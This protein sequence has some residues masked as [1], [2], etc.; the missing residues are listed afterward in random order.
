[1]ILN[2]HD[3]HCR[4]GLLE[5]M[6]LAQSVQQQSINPPADDSA[7]K[8]N[9]HKSSPCVVVVVAIV[10]VTV[11]ALC[12]GH[13][14]RFQQYNHVPSFPIAYIRGKTAPMASTK[15][16]SGLTLVMSRKARKT[17]KALTICSDSK[18]RDRITIKKSKVNHPS[19]KRVKPR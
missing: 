16:R 12:H 19:V 4:G 11:F 1:V 17:R 8:R 14:R 15:S 6:K 2:H 9:L 13:G 5:S 18:D 10:V 7:S 3:I